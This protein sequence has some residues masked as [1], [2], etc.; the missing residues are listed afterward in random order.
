MFEDIDFN[1]FWQRSGLDD[2]YIDDPLTAE[3]VG[4]CEQRLGYRLPKAY[5]ELM[6]HQNGGVPRRAAHRTKTGNPWCPDFITVEGLMSVGTEK[7]YSLCGS[8]GSQFFIDD[9][10]YPTI[11]IY[12]A[13]VPSETHE[14]LCLDYSEC[15]PTGEPC[16]VHVDQGRDFLVTPVSASFEAFVRQLEEESALAALSK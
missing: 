16:V 8:S 14:M 3:K 7:P 2:L 11:G 5:L 13:E 15:G 4:S 10:G 1:E 6:R 12:F 9:W